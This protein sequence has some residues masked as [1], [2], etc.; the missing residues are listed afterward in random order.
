MSTAPPGWDCYRSRGDLA[1]GGAKKRHAGEGGGNDQYY[2]KEVFGEG[3]T[4]AVFVH[5]GYLK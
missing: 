3:N 1:G 5:T 2:E 4:A